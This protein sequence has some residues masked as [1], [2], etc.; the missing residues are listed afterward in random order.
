[1]N[2]RTSALLLGVVATLAALWWF[3]AG[4]GAGGTRPGADG[5][6]GGEPLFESGPLAVRVEREGGE[7]VLRRE[8]GLWSQ[9]APDWFPLSE[10]A[11]REVARALAGAVARES[12]LP[13]RGG[14]TLEQAALLDPDAAVEVVGPGGQTR[15]LLGESTPGG[16]SFA[17]VE[18]SPSAQLRGKVVVIPGELH[19][20][21]YGRRDGGWFER[22]VPLPPMTAVASMALRGAGDATPVEL[23]RSGG[24][25]LLGDDG[26]PLRPEVAEGMA[27]LTRELAVREHV[28]GAAASAG[29]GVFG[30]SPPAAAWTL[31]EAGG[32]ETRLLVGR[33]GGLGDD[34]VYGLLERTQ[35]QSTL[36]SP[37]LRLPP[38][39]LLLAGGRG[40]LADPR[41]FPVAP[42]DARVL[43]LV[44][45]DGRTTVVESEGEGPARVTGG[46]AEVDA[47][48]LLRALLGL[49][50]ER[51]V[52]PPER[53]YAESGEA[54]AGGSAP[55]E[56]A[57]PTPPRGFAGTLT[58]EHGLTGRI[59]AQA[60]RR[61][62]D[63]SLRML[64]DRERVEYVLDE[65]SED[66]FEAEVLPLLRE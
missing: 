65:P 9:V 51:R 2:L 8:G 62:G 66:V 38:S 43:R 7:V 14:P 28:T 40:S 4:G 52:R 29:L 1:M 58:L 57:A 53:V 27:A 42:A 13:G 17:L 60:V 12:F 39:V 19:A 30:L 23:V 20:F 33:T 37:V 34:S 21:A 3:T 22:E 56:P 31:R 64:T 63:W 36:R 55:A 48:R 61:R 59:E 15:V 5:S 6:P 10:E 50:G 35:G 47:E 24:G 45:P 16:R 25:W 11:G 18:E 41:A 49:T 26:A 44:A 32:R 46:A 54:G